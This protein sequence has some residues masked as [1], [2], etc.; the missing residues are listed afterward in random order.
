MFCFEWK[1]DRVWPFNNTET[2]WSVRPLCT[3]LSCNLKL[4]I[5]FFIV[6]TSLSLFTYWISVHFKTQE[7]SFRKL[8]KWNW[9]T[10]KVKANHWRNGG[11]VRFYLN[12]SIIFSSFYNL[13]KLSIRWQGMPYCSFKE[14][15]IGGKTKS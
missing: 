13:E 9:D 15:C 6:A 14:N 12:F 2:K 8:K 3:S 5:L 7:S 4:N 11:K 1:F 10:Q